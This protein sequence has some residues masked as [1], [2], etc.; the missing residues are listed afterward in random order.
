MEIA[1]V[2]RGDRCRVVSRDPAKIPRNSTEKEW[3]N[4]KTRG[5]GP[6]GA[7]ET[8]KTQVPG[9]QSAPETAPIR[10]TRVTMGIHSRGR[11]VVPFPQT[12]SC[13]RR[14]SPVAVRF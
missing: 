3:D 5:S 14:A 12:E 8:R 7:K 11:G 10:T 4:K 2:F 9:G 13:V 1:A 6:S